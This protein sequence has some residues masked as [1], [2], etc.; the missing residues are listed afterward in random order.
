MSHART[1]SQTV[2]PFFEVAIPRAGE[3]HTVPPGTPGAFWLRGRVLDGAGEPV[4]DALVEAWQSGQKALGRSATDPAGRYAIFAQRPDPG[5]DAPHLELFVFARG[6][7]RH[8]LTR[9]YLPG[10]PDALA[11]DPTLASI[12]DPARRATLI[13]AAA[14]DGY[15]FDI[16]LQGDRE[17]VFFEY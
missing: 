2:G 10:D 16:R 17:T 15:A 11:V 9:V 4:P 6:L 12:S 3:D 5:P 14:D 1:P 7:L 13:A 8:L